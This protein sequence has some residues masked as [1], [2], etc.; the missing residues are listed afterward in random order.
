MLNMAV[1]YDCS[2]LC[3]VLRHF[4]PLA[5]LGKPLKESS[6]GSQ[7]EN[8]QIRRRNESRAITFRHSPASSAASISTPMGSSSRPRSRLAKSPFLR[9]PRPISTLADV[10]AS[11]SLKVFPRFPMIPGSAS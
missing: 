9:G 7:R 1:F 6:H 11:V 2:L 10:F 5:I 3:N 8:E 4:V